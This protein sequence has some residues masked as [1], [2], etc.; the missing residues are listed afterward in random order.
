[1]DLRSSVVLSESGHFIS[2][3]WAH[4]NELL[5]GFDPYLELHWIPTDKRITDEKHPYRIVHNPPPTSRMA[6]YVVMY[7]RET[8]SPEEIFA[9]I[10]AGDNWRSDVQARLDARIKSQELFNRKKHLDEMAES[11]DLAHF[12]LMRAGNYTQIRMPSGEL[13]KFDAHRFRM[14]SP[15]S[16]KR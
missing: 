2:E 14:N 5:Q 4:L 9:R 8:D 12:L 13:V 3:K 1:M 11:A 6:P 10:I 16:R 7:A 15:L